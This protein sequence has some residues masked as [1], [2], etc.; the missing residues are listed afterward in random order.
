MK[1]D[2]GPVTNPSTSAKINLMKKK[3]LF[4]VVAPL[5]AVWTIDRLTKIWAI[6]YAGP[7]FGPIAILVRHNPGA[8]LGIF[9]DLPALL[10]IVSLSTGGAFLLFSFL[11]IQYLLPPN[12]LLL[13]AAFS[14]LLGG[15]LGNVA[16]RIFSGYVVDFIVLR[17][18]SYS[19]PS[20]NLADALQWVGYFLAI[21]CLVKDGKRLWPDLNLRK[22]Y[23]VNAQFQLTYSLKLTAFALS[24]AIIAGTLSYTFMKVTVQELVG[25]THAGDHFLISYLITYSIVST[26]FC[27][28]IFFT[29]IALSHRAAGPLFA[30]E[31][32]L[33]DLFQG[34]NSS[35][36][37]RGG[38]EFKHLE[39]LADK[40]SKKWSEETE[41]I[42]FP[43]GS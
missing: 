2:Q 16:D 36:K 10:R 8:M 14:T 33:D 19:S 3:D 34:K 15:I 31:R 39:K 26:I 6:G 24:F 18:G 25:N 27:L 42:K 1:S 23:L 12:T 4:Y 40:L 29:G 38:D 11:I 43:R 35:L 37:L 30:F 32:F 9:S 28:I 13:R 17:I 21:Y 7:A 41:K 20:F 5:L 22:S